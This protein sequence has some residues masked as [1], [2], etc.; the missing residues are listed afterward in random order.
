MTT[1]KWRWLV[2]L[3]CALG[4]AALLHTDVLLRHFAAPSDKAGLVISGPRTD[5][6]DNYYYFTMLRHVRERLSGEPVRPTDPDGGDHRYVNAVSDAY[7]AALY[8]GNALYLG[9]VALTPSSRDAVLLT[10]VFQTAVLALSLWF[11][12]V[13]LGDG[14]FARKW[15][16]CFVLMY[17]G[18][19]F[20][21]AFGNSVYLGRIAYWNDDLL[22]F[23]SNPRRMV[24]PTMF[25]AAGLAAA[26]FLVRWFRDE[27]RHDLI[28]AIVF[29]I[30]TGL[31]SISVG[32]TLLLALGL[33]VAFDVLV[34]RRVSLPLAGIALAVMMAVTWSYLQLRSYSITALGQELRHGVFVGLT[35][36]WQFVLMFALCPLALWNLGKE[37]VF[38]AAL[39]VSA[40]IV[41]MFCASFYL[42]DRLW[43]RGAVIYVWAIALFAVARLVIVGVAR[44][45]KPQRVGVWV[46]IAVVALMIGFVWRAQQP[47]VRTWKGFVSHDK[48][49]LIAWIDEHVATGSVV[50][51]ADIEDAFLLPIYTSARPLYAMYGL[52]TRTMNE[53]LRRYFYNMSLF[54][55]DQRT[56]S[57]VLAVRQKD[58]YRYH[59][60]VMG[61]VALPY[62][63]QV[64]DSVIFLELVAYQAY[65]VSLSNALS[66]P[67][68]H[69]QFERI[70]RERAAE[71]AKLTYA[72]DY[73]VVDNEQPLPERFAKWSV[74]YS[75]GR[76]SILK[77]PRAEAAKA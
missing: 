13:S 72:F 52:T 61:D 73:A 8:A 27:R 70:V 46:K 77:D 53:E 43:V 49:Q 54:D 68:Q 69:E 56:I 44:L 66:D 48:W 74:V 9:A 63:G 75:N 65:V 24:N 47:D 35:I 29:S 39:I 33:S 17:A 22:T 32:A 28:L 18:L 67:V 26:G 42:G 41:G 37:K 15:F 36:K 23:R 31:F 76:Y 16:V 51:S 14:L 2:P 59:G 62:R 30:I 25:W 64:E 40:T 55:R 34:K 1:L 38:V 4:V 21:D 58:I 5:L 12:L 19:V 57:S 3:I 71:A 6:G 45:N 60:H 10:S 7:A 50:A 20:V 11:F